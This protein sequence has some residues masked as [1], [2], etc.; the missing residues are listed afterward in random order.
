MT[1]F[2]FGDCTVCPYI[3]PE[4][5]IFVPVTIVVAMFLS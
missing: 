1:A 4:H 5:I 3:C 2:D